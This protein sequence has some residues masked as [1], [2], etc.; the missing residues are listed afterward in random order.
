MAGKRFGNLAN[1]LRFTKLKPSKL[2]I[3][4]NKPLADLFI[5]QTFF[6]QMLKKSKFV[7]HSPRQTFPL[8]GSWYCIVH[9]SE[10]HYGFVVE[11]VK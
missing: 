4:I 6:C 11:I 2:A 1:H 9:C 3:T 10:Q 7:K 8:Y 5:R